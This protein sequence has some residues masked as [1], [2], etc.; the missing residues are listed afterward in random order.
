MN[1]FESE[2]KAPTDIYEYEK[3]TKGP[4]R[5]QAA[6]VATAG[7]IIFGG[8]VGGGAF[9]MN[10]GLPGILPGAPAAA[11]VDPTA[12]DSN[13]ATDPA[14]A[15]DASNLDPSTTAGDPALPTPADSTL[16]TAASSDAASTADP[17]STSTDS[18]APSSSTAPTDSTAPSSSSSA[19]PSNNQIVVPPVFN[20]N[21]D[22]GNENDGEDKG[23]SKSGTHHKHKTSTA[24]P[25]ASASGVPT[26]GSGDDEGGDDD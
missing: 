8:L 6:L 25:S 9:A 23:G 16:P 17:A 12:G 13:V 20:R 1:D 21:G 19:G 26:F 11:N 5:M 18:A 15:G 7:F 14:A 2:E 3:S 4:S 22:D 10:G 24:T